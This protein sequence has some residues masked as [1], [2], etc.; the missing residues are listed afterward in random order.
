MKIIKAIIYQHYW[1]YY[2]QEGHS[3]AKFKIF[4]LFSIYILFLELA[5]SAL[6]KAI[7]ATDFLMHLAPDLG[8]PLFLIIHVG[9]SILLLYPFLREKTFNSIINNEE[10]DT[11]DYDQLAEGLGLYLLIAVIISWAMII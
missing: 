4:I 7:F 6:S 11:D 1:K 5:I 8:L 9:S 3:G 2:P 10:Y